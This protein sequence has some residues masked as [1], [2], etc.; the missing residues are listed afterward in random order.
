MIMIMNFYSAKT[1]EVYSKALYI[2]LKFI[3]H[4]II[5]R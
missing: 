2:K 4:M 1:I 5:M 3:S